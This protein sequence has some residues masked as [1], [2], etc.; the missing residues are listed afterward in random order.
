[1]SLLDDILASKL[2][3]VT[4]GPGVPVPL[5]PCPSDSGPMVLA[6]LQEELKASREANRRLHDE[7]TWYYQELSRYRHGPGQSQSQPMKFNPQVHVE[8]IRTPYKRECE[9]HVR[10]DL[11]VSPM[12]TGIPMDPDF[13]HALARELAES[14]TKELDAIWRRRPLARQG[15]PTAGS[16]GPHGTLERP[17]VFPGS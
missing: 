2:Q 11:R 15:R 14:L 7:L 8:H 16:E 6:S 5:V 12:V 17:S 4:Q 13:V 10:A 1:M 9:T 3:E